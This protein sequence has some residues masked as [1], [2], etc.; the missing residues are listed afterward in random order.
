LTAKERIG[1]TRR[2]AL[3]HAVKPVAGV[4]ATMRERIECAPG[5]PWEQRCRR[6]RLAPIQVGGWIEFQQMNAIIGV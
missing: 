6:D 4:G 5:R 2:I 3:E 1:L